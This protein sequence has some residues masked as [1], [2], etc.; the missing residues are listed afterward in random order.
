[1]ET[2]TTTEE[3]P[4][5]WR[6]QKIEIEFQRWGELKGKYTGKIQFENNENES[7]S[8]NIRPE[9]T[10]DYLKI[11]SDDIIRGASELGQKLV[12]TLPIKKSTN[13]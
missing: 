7:F 10:E 1:M 4:K 13:V 11:M 2:T 9:M 3:K 12:E 6:L 8:F 5:V